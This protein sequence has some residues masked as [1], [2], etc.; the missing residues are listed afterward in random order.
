MSYDLQ[1]DD[2]LDFTNLDEADKNTLFTEYSTNFYSLIAV[3]KE[4]IPTHN[5]ITGKEFYEICY[6]IIGTEPIRTKYFYENNMHRS[7]N[8]IIRQLSFIRNNV[9]GVIEQAN[10][11]L[12]RYFYDYKKANDSGWAKL[13]DR[14]LFKKVLEEKGS[15]E[16]FRKE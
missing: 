5:K 6:A 10:Q 8:D 7:L 12:R 15:N 13:I 1:F 2:I 11:F 16:Q 3:L 9:D 4:Y 14:K